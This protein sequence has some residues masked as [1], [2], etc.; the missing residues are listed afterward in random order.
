MFSSVLLFQSFV[1]EEDS[2]LFVALFVLPQ[3]VFKKYM[4][5][6]W[7]RNESC[8]LSIQ[9]SLSKSDFRGLVVSLY[10]GRVL[11][12]LGDNVET[13]LICFVFMCV[14]EKVKV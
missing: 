11:D 9:K 14:D 2:V 10:W 5:V 7:F 3:P 12:Y 4:K 1:R 8:T 6:H 13:V